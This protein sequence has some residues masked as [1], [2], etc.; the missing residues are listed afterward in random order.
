MSLFFSILFFVLAFLVLIYGI[1][2]NKKVLYPVIIL[3]LLGL[4]FFFNFTMDILEWK[5]DIIF[6]REWEFDD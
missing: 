4:G 1:I 5:D 2:K 3:T 6:E